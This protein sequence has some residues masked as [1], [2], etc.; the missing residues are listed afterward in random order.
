MEIKHSDTEEDYSFVLS[1][2]AAYNRSKGGNRPLD[3]KKTL[4]LLDENGQKAGGLVYGIRG[5]CLDIDLLWLAESYR[6]NGGGTALIQ[7][8]A[9]M[10]KEA[11]CSY[12]WVTT[13]SF[14]APLFYPK[15]GF[16]TMVVREDFPFEGN[17]HYQFRMDLA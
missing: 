5:K 14:Q 17:A 15:V 13:N 3:P 2:L 10:A 12:I 8:A 11:G 6:G 9:A 7:E 4:L 1:N 16:K